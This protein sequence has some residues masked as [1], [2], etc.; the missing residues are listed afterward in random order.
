M[1][2]F[3]DDYVTRLQPTPYGIVRALLADLFLLILVVGLGLTLNS[4][5]A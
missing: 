2:N 3:R 5:V 4:V 1:E